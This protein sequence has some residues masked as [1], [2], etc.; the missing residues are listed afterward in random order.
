MTRMPLMLCAGVVA[1]VVTGCDASAPHD[2]VDPATDPRTGKMLLDVIDEDAA[3]AKDDSFDGLAGPRGAGMSSST[4]V[5]S[6]TRR[7]YQVSN[8]AGLAW[9]ANSG[10]TWDE[11]FSA[12]VDSMRAIDAADGSTTFEL[13][14]PYAGVTLPA[15]TLECAETAMFLRATFAAWHELPFFMS[16]H[17]GTHGRVHFGHF[18]IVLSSGA[19]VPGYPR[20]AQSYACLLYTSPSPRDGLLSR[21][22]SS[23]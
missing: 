9:P 15:P 22:P 13:T 7:W 16:A 2:A 10:L 8:E 17:H 11:K 4:E 12:W 21:M 3:A 1:I 20:F 14:T 5:W 6:V 19:R 18:G 23:A